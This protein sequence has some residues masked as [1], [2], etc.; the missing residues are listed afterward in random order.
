M[1]ATVSPTELDLELEIAGKLAANDAANQNN[2]QKRR[3]DDIE[4]LTTA[5]VPPLP[6]PPL[7]KRLSTASAGAFS[8]FSNTGGD[9]STPY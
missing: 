5:V 3:T 6:P 2:Q 8:L 9:G 1:T 7:G 4:P